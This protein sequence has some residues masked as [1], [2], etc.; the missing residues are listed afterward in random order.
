[1]IA[2]VRLGALHAGEPGLDDDAERSRPGQ[3]DGAEPAV[4]EG[5]DERERGGAA[6][7][8]VDA[9]AVG[10]PAGRPGPAAGAEAA[11]V[12]A[13]DVDER[14]G[15]PAVRGADGERQPVGRGG[16]R[17]AHA[18]AQA[19]RVLLGLARALAHGVQAPRGADPGAG[20]DVE[21]DA[22][23]ALDLHPPQQLRAAGGDHRHAAAGEHDG[24]QRALGRDGQ[25]PR[26]AVQADAVADRER[27]GVEHE[28]RAAGGRIDAARRR[29]RR[30]SRRRARRGRAR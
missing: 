19:Q 27:L 1:M 16:D 18:L 8:V 26:R 24:R 21:G 22:R 10:R 5:A 20:A 6:V 14:R 11:H 25:R 13:G 3:R 9:H 4:A 29:A 2:S 17:P 7:G 15:R 30:R 28:E 12:V 23:G